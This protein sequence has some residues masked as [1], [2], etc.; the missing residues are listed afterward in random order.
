MGRSVLPLAL[1]EW[2]S[3]FKL[4]VYVLHCNSLFG[5]MCSV[6]FFFLFGIP[7]CQFFRFLL[8]TL[9]RFQKRLFDGKYAIFT[10]V[11]RFFPPNSSHLS[12]NPRSSF[13]VV[14][15]VFFFSLSSSTFYVFMQ[16]YEWLHPAPRITGA[17]LWINLLLPRMWTKTTSNTSKWQ[18]CEL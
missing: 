9:L 13:F 5:R 12:Y 8:G 11:V 2:N 3:R 1:C 15:V 7:L 18:K 16:Y 4:W 10:K 17:E 6:G 14:V